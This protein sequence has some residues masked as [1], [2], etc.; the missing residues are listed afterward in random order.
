MKNRQ[1]KY[2]PFYIASVITLSACGGSNTLTSGIDASYDGSGPNAQEVLKQYSN[3]QSV[4]AIKGDL[5][6]GSGQSDDKTK[7]YF[8]LSSDTKAVTDTFSGVVTYDST[9]QYLTNGNFYGVLREGTNSAGKSVKADTAG[10][11]LN[12]SGSEFAAISVFEI[13]NEFGIGTG[14][15]VVN[16][17]P[18][19]KFNYEGYGTIGVESTVEN[20]A[21]LLFVA[22]FINNTAEMLASTT[23]LF[24]SASGLTID[25]KNGSFSGSN[26]KIGEKNSTF[27]M[28]ATI[29]GA[30]AGSNAG[31]VHGVG[32]P[33]KDDGNDGFVTFVGER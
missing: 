30:F 5:S 28:P 33:T 7:Y 13:D 24:A 19:G 2:L 14:G 32:Y 27:E 17:L 3:G 29:V 12:L 23:N 26:A 25:P 10:V 1:L 9:N 8:V 20:G 22:D 6:D 11:N 4:I 21:D 18:A 31:G 15:T 16:T